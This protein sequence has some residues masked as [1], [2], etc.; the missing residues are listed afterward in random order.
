MDRGEST[1]CGGVP[2]G[3]RGGE[4][5]LKIL[6]EPA[7]HGGKPGGGLAERVGQTVHRDVDQTVTVSERGGLGAYVDTQA[8]G[9]VG[10]DDVGC[11]ERDIDWVIKRSL[12]DRYQ[13]RHDLP[14]SSP[15]IAQIDLAYH[16]I[17]RGRGL[18]NLLERRG[19]VERKDPFKSV[20]ERVE[21]LI[22]GM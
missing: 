6:F 3:G 19:Q 14:L 16:D 1:E 22:A 5:V 8:A 11:T 7:A 10:N 15:R 12:L 18:Y 9:Q 20:D 21:R 13:N 17:R 4:E 2:A